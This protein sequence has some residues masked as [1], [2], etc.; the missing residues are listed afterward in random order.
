MV[1]AGYSILLHVMLFF[2]GMSTPYSMLPFNAGDNGLES[3]K[4]RHPAQLYLILEPEDFQCPAC[5]LPFEQLSA[6]L[7]GLDNHADLHCTLII[8]SESY[9]TAT[10]NYRSILIKQLAGFFRS[11]QLSMPVYIMGR[12]LSAMN[13]SLK[14]S[15]LLAHPHYHLIKTWPLPMS[16]H[17]LDEMHFFLTGGDE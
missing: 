4:G 2:T 11:L 3:M 14:S 12:D 7:K 15:L 8:D 10:E 9:V 13:R 6:S 16:Q 17:D 1:S 5:K